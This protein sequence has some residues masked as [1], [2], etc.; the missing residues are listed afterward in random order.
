MKPVGLVYVTRSL[1]AYGGVESHCY[2]VLT[3]L[4][5]DRYRPM[6]VTVDGKGGGVAEQF[7][8]AGIPTFDI[9]ARPSKWR[10]IMGLKRFYREHDIAI[11]H[12]HL[13]PPVS[14][15]RVAGKFARIPV[16]MCH[17][18]DNLGYSKTKMQYFHDALIGRVCEPTICLTEEGAQY[19]AKHTGL[20]REKYFRVIPNGLDLGDYTNLPSKADAR[21]ALGLP[22]DARLVSYVGRMHAW[23]N[24]EQIVRAFAEPQLA[25]VH[26]ALAGIGHDFERCQ[27]AARELGM[28]DRIHFLGAVPDVRPVYR[29]GDAYAFASGME[30]GQGLVLMEAMACGTPVA[31]TRVGLMLRPEVT[32]AEYA[33]VY[34]PTPPAIARA[35]AEALDPERAASQLAAAA[36]LLDALSMDRQ[37]RET[38]AY[39]EEM[40]DRKKVRRK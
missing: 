16:V 38:E 40:L 6:I 31:A 23:K 2:R 4:D 20:D 15:G 1:L 37:M 27:E 19:E 34:E 36:K 22:V 3:R 21:R 25:G 17:E 12:C 5:R 11:V 14:V 8:K 13:R 35:V 28:A 33:R 39:Y 26:L 30:E 9:P 10:C 32:G 18:H 24:V 7:E 29:A